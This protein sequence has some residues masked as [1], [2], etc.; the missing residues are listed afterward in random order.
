MGRPQ[1]IFHFQAVVDDWRCRLLAVSWSENGEV[2]LLALTIGLESAKIGPD[3]QKR[4]R[5]AA[6]AL[7]PAMAVVSGN[8][9]PPV[10]PDALDRWICRYLV[11]QGAELLI[12]DTL[13]R[14][15]LARQRDARRR[16]VHAERGLRSARIE[17]SAASWKKVEAVQAAQEA[18]GRGKVT[19]R[20]ALEQIIDAYRVSTKAVRP[21]RANVHEPE[22]SARADDL[23]SYVR[24]E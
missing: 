5:A 11:R 18:A 1:S 12:P 13:R 23:L 14:T 19:L 2:P 4:L 6:K 22:P 20:T 10:R 21:D 24:S 7:H 9:D 16:Q 17:M 15:V 8:A 3:Q